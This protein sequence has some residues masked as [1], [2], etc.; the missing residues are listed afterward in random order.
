MTRYELFTSRTFT[1][2]AVL[3]D[4]LKGSTAG[5]ILAR[6]GLVVTLAMMRNVSRGQV[7]SR[8]RRT[9]FSN[10]LGWYREPPI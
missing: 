4:P 5:G 10:L 1:T 8:R 9:F 6:E 2:P 3:A 7:F